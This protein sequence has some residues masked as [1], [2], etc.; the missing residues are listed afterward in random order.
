MA[1]AMVSGML[2]QGVALPRDIGCTC[3]NDPS[4]PRLAERMGIGFA[5]GVTELLNG[6]STVI[7]ACKPQQ[8]EALDRRVADLS[9]GCLVISILAGTRLSR[10]R[11]VF[12]EARAII[13][14]MP[15]TPGQVGAGIT[16]FACEGPISATEHQEV[17]AILGS[18]GQV[19]EVAE[20][21]LDAITAVSGSGP[22]YF[23]EFTLAL[24]EAALRVGLPMAHAR[25]LAR[26]TMIG[27]AR[28]L[29]ASEASVEELRNQVTSPGGT[30][31]AA[32][33]VLSDRALRSVLAEAVAAARD[34]SEELAG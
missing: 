24:E 10:L 5:A 6:A 14:A 19:I 15:N 1:S 12:P 34:R 31:E 30:T 16:G 4:G 28:L 3:G 21:D 8:L 29:E 20:S 27:A 22:A 33:R 13:R 23:F 9:R 18:L 17:M 32:L 2:R 26:E 7:V 25:R 11:E